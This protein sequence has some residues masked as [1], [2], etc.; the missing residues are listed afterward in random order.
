[1]TYRELFCFW[2][3][4]LNTIDREIIC[5]AKKGLCYSCNYNLSDIGIEFGENP[6][7]YIPGC[8][9][10]IPIDKSGLDGILEPVL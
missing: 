10:F 5:T 2:Q 6:F 4:E 8:R 7:A 9:N 1:M 3:S